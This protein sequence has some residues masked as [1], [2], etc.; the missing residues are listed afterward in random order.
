MDD[1]RGAAPAAY[2]RSTRDIA[3]VDRAVLH[4]MACAGS[5]AA[6][7]R[8]WAK[9]R[10]HVTVRLDGSVV[11]CWDP[12]ARLWYGSGPWNVTAL[13]IEHQGNFPGRYVAGA[14]RWWKPNVAG[15]D[16]PTPAQVASSLAVLRAAQAYL[17]G[18]RYVAPHRLVERR[19]P[20]CCGPDLWRQVG[21]AAIRDLGLALPDRA[22]GGANLPADWR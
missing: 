8:M 20:A 11:T 7:S 18:L 4:Q 3:V 21:E 14:P 15:R 16:L 2:L 9:V 6:G 10:A 17:P 22:P 12:A 5:W 13:T 19:K 1:R